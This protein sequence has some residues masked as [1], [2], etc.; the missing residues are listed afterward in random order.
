MLKSSRMLDWTA[1]SEQVW[2]FP[3]LQYLVDAFAKNKAP[4]KCTYISAVCFKCCKWKHTR[5]MPIAASKWSSAGFAVMGHT[6]SYRN[7]VVLHRFHAVVHPLPSILTWPRRGWNMFHQWICEAKLG[8]NMLPCIYWDIL[9]YTEKKKKTTWNNYHTITTTFKKRAPLLPTRV[10]LRFHWPSPQKK[11]QQ[12]QTKPLPPKRRTHPAITPYL[13][14]IR[15]IGELAQ[16]IANKVHRLLDDV[17][18]VKYQRA[19]W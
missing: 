15:Q 18:K 19:P 10:D 14:A 8:P 7:A 3:N 6:V 11:T 1:G 12:Q 13:E 5:I 2:C 16:A 9:V 4:C 17:M